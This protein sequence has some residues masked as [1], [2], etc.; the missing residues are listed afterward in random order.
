ML[1]YTCCC[2][3]FYKHYNVF[4]LIKPFSV[5]HGN[6]CI[7]WVSICSTL[8]SFTL[9]YYAVI[10]TDRGLFCDIYIL[11]THRSTQTWVWCLKTLASH[12]VPGAHASKQAGL[13]AADSRASYL[14][15][16][17]P[18]LSGGG[19]LDSA[20]PLRQLEDEHLCIAEASA[21]CL[22]DSHSH[23]QTHI[24]GRDDPRTVTALSRRSRWWTCDK[25]TTTGPVT[26]R[27][28]TKR[29]A[30]DH[31][32]MR[33]GYREKKK[34][35]WWWCQWDNEEG[36]R[37]I[38]QEQKCV[39]TSLNLSHLPASH[40]SSKKLPLSDRAETC[41]RATAHTHSK[42][43][44]SIC[45]HTTTARGEDI[46]SGCGTPQSRRKT[47]AA[48][49]SITSSDGRGVSPLNTKMRRCFF[50]CVFCCCCCSLLPCG[51]NRSPD[52]MC[53]LPFS[54]TGN[55][56]LLSL[57]LSLSLAPS[58]PLSLSLSPHRLSVRSGKRE[59]AWHR[60][61]ALPPLP[62]LSAE[63]TVMMA[64]CEL[65]S[66]HHKSVFH[67]L[68]LMKKTKGQILWQDRMTANN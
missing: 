39:L 5:L 25:T 50:V 24:T 2:C 64:H 43:T 37:W 56:S 35:W 7:H 32:P 26:R 31:K 68:P 16:I 13:T 18:L 49:P 9:C 67:W 59:R 28:D 54:V 1:Y 11:H 51:I 30:H 45:G 8:P 14:P 42:A 53:S 58:P 10:P 62:L 65:L 6:V 40:L 15:A 36:R 57:A 63:Q 41:P 20:V 33:G 55:R 3:F 19:G 17:R 60:A 44:L 34:R 38:T 27:L 23:T 46:G 4:R 29:G 52:C 48:Q 22:R 61:R 66:A 47:R 21:V 12:P